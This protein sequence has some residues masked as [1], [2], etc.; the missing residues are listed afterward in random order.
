M[1]SKSKSIVIRFCCSLLFFPI[2]IIPSF[3]HCATV[4]QDNPLKTVPAA[5][6][7]TIEKY[8]KGNKITKIERKEEDNK[9]V[10]EVEFERDGREIE[11]E[12]TSAGE[13]VEEQV[14]LDTLPTVVVI[15]IQKFAGDGTIKKIERQVEND[16]VTYYAEII[17]D[18][19]EFEIDISLTGELLQVKQEY[20]EES[21]ELI[22]AKV[23]LKPDFVLTGK[24]KTVDTITFWEA[25]DPNETL[26]FVTAKSN[27]LVEVWKYPFVNNE[28][29]PLVHDSFGRSPVNGVAVD[30]DTDLLYVAVGEPASTVCVFELPSLK[31]KFQ[32]IKGNSNLG[33]EPNICLLKRPDGK[34]WVYVTSKNA[35]HIHE[36]HTGKEIGQIPQAMDVETVFADGFHQ[37][38]YVPDEH[39]GTGIYAYTPDGQ[40]F[41]KNGTNRFGGGGIIQDDAEGIWI[42]SLPAVGNKDEGRG[43]IILSDQR[44]DFTD[45]EFF[46]RETW[47]H[48]GTLRLDEVNNTD[49][50]ASTQMSLKDYPLGLFVAIN[51]DQSTVGIGWDK[52][53]KAMA[54][55]AD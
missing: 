18:S 54:I 17:K 36:A 4:T 28:L 55:N 37:I 26:M 21:E 53:L 52:I 20:E 47:K 9:V 48:F 19:K 16:K 5:A 51:N 24:G 8:A 41:L 11:I 27:S 31:Y 6:R 29:A 25:P 35:I 1:M 43:Y 38:I 30:Q 34:T 10:F 13:I 23:T 46:N 40:P 50:I 12:V 7:A 42:F 2:F 15:T 22:R 3:V 39:N 44:K 14:F 49:G 45:F 33:G 32:F